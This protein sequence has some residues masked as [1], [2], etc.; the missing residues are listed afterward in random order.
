MLNYFFYSLTPRCGDVHSTLWLP[1][2]FWYDLHHP[3]LTQSPKPTLYS[4][5]DGENMGALF[6]QIMA[7]DFEVRSQKSDHLAW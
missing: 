5:D 7:G 1:T 3:T 2:L 6:E 4:P